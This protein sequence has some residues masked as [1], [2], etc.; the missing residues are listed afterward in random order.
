MSL[1]VI[2]F[3]S[4]F[5]L[6][7]FLCLFLSFFFSQPLLSLSPPFF[8]PEKKNASAEAHR[9]VLEGAKARLLSRI[10]SGEPTHEELLALL[11]ASFP[12]IGL[13]PLRDVP[14][15]CL[16]RLSP[17]VPA[18]FLQQLAAADD[19]LFAELPAP[20]RR[21]VW[22][23]DRHLLGRHAAPVAAAYSRERATVARA[24]DGG[25]ALPSRRRLLSLG[26]AAVVASSS[27]PAA[28]ASAA[29]PAGM[30]AAHAAAASAAAG[31][32]AGGSGSTKAASASAGAS[33]SNKFQQQLLQRIPQP[34]RAARA[35]SP[36][37]RK[38]AGMVG[39]SSPVY[40]G[41]VDVVSSRVREGFGARGWSGEGGKKGGADEEEEE[42]LGS[43]S[44]RPSSLTL[45]PREAAFA[46]LRGQLLMA[47]HDSGGGGGGAAAAAANATAA[48]AATD[49]G[50]ADADA[51]AAPG[52][53]GGGAA[54]ARADPV[55]IL[56]WTL[57][58]ALRDGVLEGRRLQELG[59]FFA[60]FEGAK[61]AT[62]TADED[63]SEDEDEDDEERRRAAA[64]AAA[65]ASKRTNTHR[66]R[67][68]KA[69]TAAA[70]AA[71]AAAAAAADNDAESSGVPLTSAKRGGAGGGGNVRG[72]GGGG[73]GSNTGGRGSARARLLADTSLILRDPSTMRLMAHAALRRLEA[74]VEGEAA[75]AGSLADDKE[76]GLLCRLLQLGAGARA[77]L[78]RGAGVGLGGLRNGGGAAGGYGNASS[79]SSMTTLLPPSRALTGTLLPT[80]AGWALEAA[81]EAEDDEEEEKDGS[82][83]DDDDS[84]LV[85]AADPSLVSLLAKDE[86][87]RGLAQAYALEKVDAA[88]EASVKAAAAAAAAASAAVAATAGAA[89]ATAAA[90]KN[91]ASNAAAARAASKAASIAAGAAAPP[92]SALA[93]ALE[94]FLSDAAATAAGAFDDDD[95]DDGGEGGGDKKAKRE[96]VALTAAASEWSPF[97]V[98]LAQ[99]LALGASSS[100]AALAAAE[101]ARAKSSSSSSSGGAANANAA[102][103]KALAV[104]RLP[105]RAAAA[106]PEGQLWCLCVDRLLTSRVA[107]SE[108]QAQ[109]ELLRCLIEAALAGTARARAGGSSDSAG[110]VPSA[111]AATA[112]ASLALDLGRRAEAVIAAT[113]RSRG[114]LDPPPPPSLRGLYSALSRLG[115]LADSAPGLKAYLQATAPPPAKAVE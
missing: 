5:S 43:G 84:Q 3:L 38:L 48:A 107:D 29:A 32:A 110:G 65:A 76:L 83:G 91:A 101:A 16:G 115:G 87:S 56:A 77:L 105:A 19:E 81:M 114:C 37:L 49:G 72:G 17:A 61:G 80:L 58:A 54:I 85:P 2:F 66:G 31:A 33:S 15:A 71:T 88:V 34:R 106:L 35:A 89:T 64:A 7:F 60:Q 45:T 104:S 11:S 102:T 73:G 25:D 109:E 12:F 9:Y 13:A 39:R 50:D 68:R 46:A 97:C 98:A 47:L 26:A 93:A 86:V 69:P 8:S 111:A 42:E 90:V 22:E 103:K 57:D 78:L 20:V 6:S 41:I 55:H 67:K 53:G 70:A 95:E 96:A 28:A 113:G 40:R 23:R 99:L 4:F 1:F 36:A 44:R 79:S 112:A 108:V 52:G 30:Q 10:A 75:G 100:S 24:L 74:C 62:N 18:T 92:L 94:A 51:A 27:V 82:A 63:D 59:N 14:L 21:A